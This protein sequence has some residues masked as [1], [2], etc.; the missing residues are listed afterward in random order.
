MRLSYR[1]YRFKAYAPNSGKV[2]KLRS[3]AS[4]MWRKALNFCLEMAKQTRPASSF[5][6]HPHVYDRIR[7]FGLPSQLACDCRDKAFEAYASHMALKRQ[8]RA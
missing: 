2:L 5:D 7:G 8:G 3:F 4:G 6:L 1:T